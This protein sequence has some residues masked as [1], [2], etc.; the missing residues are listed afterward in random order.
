MIRVFLFCTF[1]A[2]AASCGQGTGAADANDSVS[3]DSIPE[4]SYNPRV[5]TDSGAKQ[6][7]LDSTQLKD[8]LEKGQ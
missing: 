6:M 4:P 5:D 7:N 1:L 2:F 3:T 8:S